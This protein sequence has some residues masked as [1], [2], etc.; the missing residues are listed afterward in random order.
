MSVPPSLV[1][2]SGPGRPPAPG[3]VFPTETELTAKEKHAC[4]ARGDGGDVLG[5]ALGVAV[6]SPA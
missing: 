6:I 4:G 5:G 2:R 3:W 1:L